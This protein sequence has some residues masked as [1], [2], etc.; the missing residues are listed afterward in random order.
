MKKFRS[1]NCISLS[2]IF[3]LA[4]CIIMANLA[5]AD[6]GGTSTTKA[7][8]H[9]P[10]QD[11]SNKQ[12]DNKNGDPGDESIEQTIDDS[13]YQRGEK[14][15]QP[16][17]LD[18]R[19]QLINEPQQNNNTA[20]DNTPTATTGSTESIGNNDAEE[21]L[22]AW[23]ETRPE[24][25][26]A[27]WLQLKSGE[28]LR[29]RIIV[30]QKNHLEFDS[31]ELNHIE[32][33]WN[34]VKYLKSYEPYRLRFDGQEI[35]VGAI[36][37]TEDE[38]RIFTGYDDQVLPRSHLQAIASARE[39]EISYWSSKVTFSVNLRKGNTDQT[40]FTSKINAKR[41]TTE[42]RLIIDY[43]GN[44]TEVKET[45]TVNNH[46]LNGTLDYF[47]TRRLFWTVIAA[48]YFRDPFQNIDKRFVI[49]TAAG[50]ALVD[51]GDSEWNISLGPGF[52]ETVFVSVQPGNEQKET[53]FTLI[54]NTN[55]DTKLNNRVDLKGLYTATLG[56]NNTG[57]YS[58]HSIFTVETELTTKLDLDVSF[59]WD[60]I[61]SP[62][63]YINNVIP[64]SDDFRILVG[65]GYDL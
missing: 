61:R 34:K 35:I 36:E 19:Q 52:Q 64:E 32:F 7:P 33:K 23:E 38:V 50:Y 31:D 42:S 39:T 51:T 49:N 55:F 6:S 47:I 37:I 4:C 5:K 12:S 46:R 17:A 2:T 58:H 3:L 57:N 21:T 10:A 60:H 43:L 45:E 26:I 65:L 25:V 13:D 59:V 56:D 29:G 22:Y 8:L 15:P 11:Q 24:K 53:S 18:S 16:P 1:L 40:D 48:E 28:W 27:D 20:G 9:D 14:T 54:L 41:R 63:A 62:V 30:L 44:F